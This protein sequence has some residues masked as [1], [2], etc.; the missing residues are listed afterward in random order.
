MLASY[1][2]SYSYEYV[3]R[4]KSCFIKYPAIFNNKLDISISKQSHSSPV[5]NCPTL[6]RPV[7]VGVE[8]RRGNIILCMIA[9]QG[10]VAWPINAI[11]IP[12]Q[13]V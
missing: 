11:D 13:N 10:E 9:Y 3:S 6:E 12:S 4:L 5:L 7:G 1:L 8:S 2:A